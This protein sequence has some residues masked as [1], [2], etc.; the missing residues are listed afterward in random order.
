MTEFRLKSVKVGGYVQ[1]NSRYK[2]DRSNC[3]RRCPID[4]HYEVNGYRRRNQE[5]IFKVDS[6]VFWTNESK[7]PV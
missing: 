5:S 7:E 3:G 2:F 6:G 4:G 1:G